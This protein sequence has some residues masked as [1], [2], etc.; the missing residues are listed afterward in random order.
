MKIALLQIGKTNE[1]YI[2]D[3][4][5]GYSCR[6]RKYLGFDIITIPDLKNTRNMPSQEQRLKESEKIYKLLNGDDYIVLLDEKGKE[7]ST[8]EFSKH[9]NKIFMLPK[10]RVVFVIGGPYGFSA[11]AYKKADLRMSLSR[12]TF[13]HQIVRLLFAEQLYRVLTVVNGDP[14]HHE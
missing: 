14:Y 2:S 1:K 4:V 12:M 7:F 6:I 10:K 8:I 3:G 5:D 11:E 9:L 13:S